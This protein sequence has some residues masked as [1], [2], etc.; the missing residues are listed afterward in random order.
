MCM[1]PS[2]WSMRKLR[3][4]IWSFFASFYCSCNMF[5]TSSWIAKN[6]SK[7]ILVHNYDQL[8]QED[9]IV[10][11]RCTQGTIALKVMSDLRR[12]MS[13]AMSMIAKR[14]TIR[15]K[16]LLL[17]VL[18]IVVVTCRSWQHTLLMMW[19]MKWKSCAE[20]CACHTCTILWCKNGPTRIIVIVISIIKVDNRYQ[21][22]CISL[23]KYQSRM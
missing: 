5:T 18:L 1:Y 15:E 12:R 21:V 6:F 22:G 20:E 14:P 10:V 17:L 7:H 4:L 9:M 23:Y 11:E 16:I 19:V 2:S 13:L 8:I 3:T